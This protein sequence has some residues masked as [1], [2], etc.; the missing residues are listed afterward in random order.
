MK[1][2]FNIKQIAQIAQMVIMYKTL[3]VTTEGQMF[4]A[5]APAEEAARTKNMILDDSNVYVG[6]LKMDESMVSVDKLKKYGKDT[7]EFDKLFV[8][9]KIPV[10]KNK[11]PQ[12]ERK[13]EDKT[14]VDQKTTDDVMSALG[15]GEKKTKGKAAEVAVEPAPAEADVNN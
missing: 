5:E 7:E 11:K 10:S 4:R 14:E 15:L 2:N 8:N 12:F 3:Y 9:A 13:T 1:T 6:I